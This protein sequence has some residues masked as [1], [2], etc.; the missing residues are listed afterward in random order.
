M[1]LFQCFV[2]R[3]KMIADSKTD[4]IDLALADSADILACAVGSPR[5]VRVFVAARSEVRDDLLEVYCTHVES[6]PQLTQSRNY[7]LIAI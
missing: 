6:K 3:D 1:T 2:Q 5:D 7:D 4:L